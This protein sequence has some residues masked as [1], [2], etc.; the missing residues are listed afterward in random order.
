VQDPQIG[1]LLDD[2]VRLLRGRYVFTAQDYL[3]GRIVRLPSGRVGSKS[4]MALKE[5]LNPKSLCFVTDAKHY[6]SIAEDVPKC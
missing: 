6:G 2:T 5:P 1:R 3:E 4:E